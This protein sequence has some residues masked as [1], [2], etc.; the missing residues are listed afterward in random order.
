MALVNFVLYNAAAAGFVAGIQNLQLTGADGVTPV[1]YSDFA[2]VVAASYVFAAEVDAVLQTV[3]S[4][5]A[6]IALLLN[7]GATRVPG[8]SSQAN[9]AE[10]LPGAM[11]AVAKVAWT[12]RT[13]PTNEDGTALAQAD[14][15]PQANF[16]VAAFVE[17]CA[18]T[19]NI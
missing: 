16:V 6:N 1:A 3:V 17:W 4:P 9:A 11:A 13:V 8:S 18:S 5:P 14:Y 19:S 10:S 7:T 15:Q 12:G 2:T